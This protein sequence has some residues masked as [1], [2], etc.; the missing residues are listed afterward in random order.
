[1]QVQI[2]VKAIIS[3]LLENTNSKMCPVP[4]LGFL[5]QLTSEGNFFPDGFLNEYEKSMLEVDKLGMVEGVN[6]KAKLAMTGFFFFEK[7][8]VNKIL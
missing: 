8:L 1:M 7:V 5:A 6:I 4:L 2:R 3:G